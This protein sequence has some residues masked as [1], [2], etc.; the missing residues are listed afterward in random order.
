MLDHLPLLGSL[1]RTAAST[2]QRP[3]KPSKGAALLVLLASQRPRL[4][5]ALR[6]EVTMADDLSDAD[7]A[8]RFQEA[9]EAVRASAAEKTRRRCARC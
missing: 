2:M 7:D 3:A 5:A 8:V 4:A 9:C 1:C 6:W